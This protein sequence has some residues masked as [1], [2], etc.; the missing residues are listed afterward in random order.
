MLLLLYVTGLLYTY[1]TM[2]LVRGPSGL[3]WKEGNQLLAYAQNPTGGEV[4]SMADSYMV[5]FIILPLREGVLP[6]ARPPSSMSRSASA[7]ARGQK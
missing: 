3:Y 4:S 6:I 1:H 2:K 5:E 7:A